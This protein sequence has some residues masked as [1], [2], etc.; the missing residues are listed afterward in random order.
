MAIA[1]LCLLAFMAVAWVVLDGYV[2]GTGINYLRMAKTEPERRQVLQTVLPLWDGDEVYLVTMAAATVFAFPGLYASAFSGL[3]LP[4]FVLL[5]LFMMRAFALEL[6]DHIDQR[7]WQAFWDGSLV[8]SSAIATFFLGVAL[9][10]MLRGVPLGTSGYFFLPL[11]TDLRPSPHPGILDWYTALIGVLAF[12]VITMH[13]ALWVAYR[14]DGEPRQRALGRARHVWPAVVIMTIVDSALTFGVQPQIRAN[15]AQYPWGILF[16]A[17]AIAGLAAIAVF[18][19]S[20]A[21][22]LA[23]TAS[24]LYLFGMLSSVAFGLFPDVLPASDGAEPLTIY[25]TGSGYAQRVAL[26]WFIP[27]MLLAIGYSA[28]AHLRNAGKVRIEGVDAQTTGV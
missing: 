21:D 1:W 26:A 27:G 22:L 4:L 24:S 3:Y 11:W 13:G 5:W 7:F 19:W 23:F 18:V 28:Y 17:A 12:L 16:P 25:N 20:E 15:L 2:F 6:R 10:N 14:T 8:L 9:G